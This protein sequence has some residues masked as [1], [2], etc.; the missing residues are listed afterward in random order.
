M[1]IWKLEPMLVSNGMFLSKAGYI[2][3]R[4]ET[5][6]ALPIHQWFWVCFWQRSLKI[7]NTNH[8]SN[9]LCYLLQCLIYWNVA[10]NYCKWASVWL[11]DC[12]FIAISSLQISSSPEFSNCKSYSHCTSCCLSVSLSF[13]IEYLCKCELPCKANMENKHSTNCVLHL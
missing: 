2:A 12:C 1:K 4:V 6:F 10:N 3:W 11:F 8:W 5:Y 13:V 9:I 7:T